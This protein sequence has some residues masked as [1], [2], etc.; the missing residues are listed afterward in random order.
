MRRFVALTQ[1][2]GKKNDAAQS[3]LY[4]IEFNNTVIFHFRGFYKGRKI[5]N[6][7][8]ICDDEL[9]ES[10]ED[11]LL[12]LEYLELAKETLVCRLVALYQIEL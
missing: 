11:Y 8:V 12:E 3:I 5:A 6:I 4:G 2:V 10:G 7:H 1:C 9:F